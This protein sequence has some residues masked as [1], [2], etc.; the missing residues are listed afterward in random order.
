MIGQLRYFVLTAGL[1]T[2]SYQDIKYR[3]IP[4]TIT[5]CCAILGGVLAVFE[6]WD[7]TK[8]ALIGF[9]AALAVGVILWLVGAF[10]AGDAKLYAALG[11]LLG[12][13]GALNSF[14]YSMLVAGILGAGMLLARHQLWARLKRL[15]RY[16][17]GLFL[18]G[19]PAPYVPAEEGKHE[20]PL[21]P[22]VAV[23]TALALILPAF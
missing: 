20:L 15:G 18:T 4:N 6:G 10:R 1:L 13:R 21:A 17:K 8:G 3:K 7:V 5:V 16:V 14:L 12:W 9:A 11:A 2:A 19:K 22:C 23:G